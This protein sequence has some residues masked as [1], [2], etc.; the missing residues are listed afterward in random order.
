ML[1]EDL[2]GEFRPVVSVFMNAGR[3]GDQC[4][5]ELL[6]RA[7][8]LAGSY[9]AFMSGTDCTGGM[10]AALVVFGAPVSH[11]NDI[12]RAEGFMRDLFSSPGESTPSAGVTYGVVFSGTFGGTRRATYTVLG[13]RVNLAAR[14]MRLADPGTVL[15]G[16]GFSAGS[17]LLPT[18]SR[19]VRIR[20]KE[21]PV[22]VTDLSPGWP[23]PRPGPSRATWWDGTGSSSG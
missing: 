22:R 14:L 15:A 9:G 18:G 2:P 3:A 8:E 19:K 6:E 21:D 11:E 5:D 7:L 13:D 4:S 17:L 20:G 12:R 1:R 23:A 10:A 16:P